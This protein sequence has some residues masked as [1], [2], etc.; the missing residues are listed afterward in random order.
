MFN[1]TLTLLDMWA[2]GCILAELINRAPLFPG[3]N[4]MKQLGSIIKVL[5]CPSE[6]FIIR[7]QK[8]AFR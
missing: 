7:S 8:N 1:M 4:T 3:E 2:V 6:S 5:G